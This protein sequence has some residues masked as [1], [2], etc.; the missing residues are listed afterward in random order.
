MQSTSSQESGAG[1]GSV[2][3]GENRVA[4]IV[5]FVLAVAA[6]VAAPLLF[7]WPQVLDAAT[8]P[9]PAVRDP[10]AP[11]TSEEVG[12]LNDKELATWR[13]RSSD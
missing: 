11:A 3:K 6:C 13:L 10:A 9:A 5:L 4:V 7:T 2:R 8:S 1:S 12:G